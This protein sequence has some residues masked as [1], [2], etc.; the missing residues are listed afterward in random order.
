[1]GSFDFEDEG[2][3]IRGKSTSRFLIKAPLLFSELSITLKNGPVKNKVTVY[4]GGA[5]YLVE[6]EPIQASTIKFR[7]DNRGRKFI[8]TDYFYE[9]KI[10]SD[11]GFIPKIL[12]RTV[13]DGRCLGVYMFYPVVKSEGTS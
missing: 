5:R 3:W 2:C 13:E 9:L 11:N 10:V 7:M 4:V 6:M 12:D 1:M 8:L